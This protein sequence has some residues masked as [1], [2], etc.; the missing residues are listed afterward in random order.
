MHYVNLNIVPTKDKTGY[1][2]LT[3]G[4]FDPLV[5]ENLVEQ[6]LRSLIRNIIKE[7]LN[8]ES[9]NINGKIVR[10]YT[11]NGDTSYNV[12]YDDGTKDKIYVNDE[13][14]NDINQ[15]HRNAI[16]DDAYRKQ[17]SKK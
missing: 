17:F 16:G 1:F 15:L 11:Q 13:G 10:T 12:T 7:A 4:E 9:I 2:I 8:E 14:W 3:K 6:K 5:T